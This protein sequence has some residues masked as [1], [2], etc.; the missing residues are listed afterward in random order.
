MLSPVSYWSKDISNPLFGTNTWSNINSNVP[1]NGV[2]ALHWWMNNW[3]RNGR[4][5]CLFRW[6]RWDGFYTFL[7]C[8]TWLQSIVVLIKNNTILE[9]KKYIQ[10]RKLIKKILKLWLKP[11]K[12]SCFL[13]PCILLGHHGSNVWILINFVFF[14]FMFI[15][16]SP[17]L[18]VF[19]C[20]CSELVNRTYLR[21][22]HANLMNRL[23]GLIPLIGWKLFLLLDKLIS[24]EKTYCAMIKGR[25]NHNSLH[26]W[27]ELILSL[28][29]PPF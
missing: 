21:A 24:W 13:F 25:I 12:I 8:S 29:R 1:V 23:N 19:L 3:V 14:S 4:I 5:W 15:I 10:G 16:F 17:G 27:R 9:L 11:I 7:S 20:C 6:I 18:V 28:N 22:K 2:P 26:T